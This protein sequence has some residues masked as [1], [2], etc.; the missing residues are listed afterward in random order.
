[1]LD[2]LTTRPHPRGVDEALLLV[3]EGPEMAARARA[4]G[5]RVVAL[6][7][8][9]LKSRFNLSAA[10]LM[11]VADAAGRVRY[12]GGYTTHKQG[13]AP[14]DLEILGSLMRKRSVAELPVFGC[15]V[16]KQLQALLD[17]L[18]LKYSKGQ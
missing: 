11:V 4:H 8:E 5:Y 10:P 3:G 12:A 18:G 17:P 1:L 15:A 16:S 2:H 6:R 9:E 14:Q 13:P 7:P